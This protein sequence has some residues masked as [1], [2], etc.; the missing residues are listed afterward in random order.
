MSPFLIP[1]VAILAGTT[2]ALAFP[3]VRAY[4]RKVELGGQQPSVPKELAERLR[5]MEQA[6][7][8]IAVEVER[9]AEGQR[10]TTKLL[11][12][13][14]QGAALPPGAGVAPLATEVTHAR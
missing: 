6:I 14:S 10:F 13:R 11:A 5:H 4:A 7:D 9:I 2:M 1:I 12:E 8:A 3:L